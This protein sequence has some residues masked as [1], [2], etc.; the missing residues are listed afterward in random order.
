MSIDH[1]ENVKRKTWKL[2][3][4]QT[5]SLLRSGAVRLNLSTFFHQTQITLKFLSKHSFFSSPYPSGASGL[6]NQELPIAFGVFIL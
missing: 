4:E 2:G 6:W 1:N 5:E 3:A